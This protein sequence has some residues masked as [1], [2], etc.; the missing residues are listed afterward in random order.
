MQPKIRIKSKKASN[1]SY[2]NFMLIFG[3]VEPQSES[4]FPFLYI[5][6]FQTYCSLETPNST[7]GRVK[8]TR[9]LFGTQFNS[10][11]LL[12]ETFF[13]LMRTFGGIEP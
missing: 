8:H 13:D 4:N 12:F 7:V 11:Q 5:I 10:T 3:S 9:S 2:F 6:R 1:K